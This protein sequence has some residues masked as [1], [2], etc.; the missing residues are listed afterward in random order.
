[1]RLKSFTVQKYRSIIAAKRIPVGNKTILV[2]PNNEGKSNILRALMMAMNILTRERAVRLA[3]QRR[4]TIVYVRRLYEW[5]TDFPVSLQQKHPNGQTTIILEF[6]LSK[7]ELEAFRETVGSRLTGTLPLQI[8]IGRSE[9]RVTMH[10]KGPGSAVLS[11]KSD[12]IAHFVTDKIDFQQ[13][14]AVRTAQSAEEVVAEMVARQLDRLEGNADYQAALQSVET[15]QQPILDELSRSIHKTLRQFLPDVQDVQIRIPEIARHRAMRRACEI[16]VNDGTP[17]LLKYKGDGAQ[18]L[19]ALGI[20]RHASETGAKG[21]NLVIAIEEPESHLHPN[22]IHELKKV[23]DELSDKHQVLI[24]THNPLFVDR[25]TLANNILVKNNRGKPASS[26]KQIR[27][28]L[29]VRASDNLRHAEIVLLVEGEDDKL[30]VGSLLFHYSQAL[31]EALYQNTLAIDTL[32]GGANLVYKIGLVRDSLC[33]CHIL[34]DDDKAGRDAFDKARLQGLILDADVN[35][36]IAQGLNESELEDLYD[37]DVYKEFLLNRYRVSID[38]PKFQSR[39][40]WSD[41]IRDCFQHC[42]KQWNDRVEIEVK[43]AVAEVVAANPATA[44]SVHQRASFDSL[45][46]A[47]EKRLEERAPEA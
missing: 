32:A 42:G 20:I 36:C 30:A 27:E 47:L 43:N 7:E 10:K 35:F 37:A 21:K 6:Q 25:V 31:K 28:I 39:K 23:I 34:L 29:G 13:I 3:D 2:G 41:R 1:M 40:K 9:A 17:T 11:K 44:L 22:A 26:I 24:T 19:A 14:E 38:S 18:S 33:L 4:Q 12:L 16:L 8:E 5:E 45:V 46:Q 15:L